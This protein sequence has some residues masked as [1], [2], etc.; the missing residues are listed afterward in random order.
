MF[1]KRIAIIGSFALTTLTSAMAAADGGALEGRLRSAAD[2]G[3]AG[4]SAHAARARRA[5]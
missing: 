5:G 3:D 2:R 1:F 4:G